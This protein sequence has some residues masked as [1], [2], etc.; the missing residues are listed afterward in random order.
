[1]IV[2]MN[3][4][5]FHSLNIPFPKKKK[6]NGINIA[7]HDIGNGVPIFMIPPWG[8]SSTVFLP[9]ISLLKDKSR[10]I[11]IDLPG[12]SGK[13]DNPDSFNGTMEEHSLALKEFIESFGFKMY[14]I[15]GY[16]IGGLIALYSLKSKHIDPKFILL[17][18]TYLEGEKVL[19]IPRHKFIIMIQTLYEAAP[20]LKEKIEE[21]LYSSV[22][23]S[24][25]NDKNLQELR[26]SKI[27]RELIED[28]SNSRLKSL[29]NT[30]VDSINYNYYTDQ[31]K[32]IPTYLSYSENDLSFIKDD[33]KELKKKIG[34]E[35]SIIPKEKH[36][37][38]LYK[39][40]ESVESIIDFLE[41]H[42]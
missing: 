13:S 28:I 19:K 3:K 16:S 30:V 34:I 18:S 12:C 35:P 23:F 25:K 20:A 26:G 6:I 10:W 1:M 42:R 36:N 39:P 4:I 22:I 8:G 27:E 17:V 21:F 2:I 40:Q 29:F 7:F 11:P 5:N 31:L 37:H 14:G 33:M 24:N 38:L 9:L 15:F 41:K 32:E